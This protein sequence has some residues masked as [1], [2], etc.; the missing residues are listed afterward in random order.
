MNRFQLFNWVLIAFVAFQFTACT[1]EPLDTDFPDENDPGLLEDGQFKAMIGNT[2]FLAES[3]TVV[4][5]SNNELVITGTKESTGE[6]ITI[7]VENAGTGTFNLT[8]GSGTQNIGIYF[9]EEN[10]LNPYTTSLAFGGT[11]Q[12]QITDLNVM[13]LTITGTFS[14]LGAR[15]T[16][17][18]NGDPIVDANGDPVT[19]NIAITLGAFKNLPYDFEEIDEEDPDDTDPFFANVNGEEFVEDSFTAEVRVVG[20]EN[21]VK[22]EARTETGELLRIDIPE[23]VGIGT[24]SMESISNGAKLIGIYNDGQGGNNLTSNPGTITITEF[25]TLSGKIKATFSFTGTDPVGGSSDTVQVT[26]GSLNVSYTPMPGTND[27]FSVKVDDEDFGTTSATAIY[28]TFAGNEIIRITA[29]VGNELLSVTFPGTIEAGT[30]EMDPTLENFQ[31]I[32]GIYAPDTENNPVNYSSNSGILI[33]NSYNEVT[34]N[35]EGRFSFSA[36]DPNG[37]DPQTFEVTE[38]QFFL[39]VQ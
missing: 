24:F 4:L 21:V 9:D 39:T 25:S 22:I 32:V 7:G 27:P 23:N 1:N 20:D 8:S 37:V 28:T 33:I 26:Q 36:T 35:I 6:S 14:I 31:N 16:F 38:G 13:D 3:T 19:E 30:Y 34:G 15:P 12:L 5:N 2:E 11:G 18:A 10:T 29:T 17:D